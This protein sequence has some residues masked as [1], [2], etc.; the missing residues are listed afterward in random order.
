MNSGL[1]AMGEFCD[2]LEKESAIQQMQI[3]Q[4][5]NDIREMKHLNL[6]KFN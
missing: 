5:Q 6:P 3:L 1:E 2:K 4:I